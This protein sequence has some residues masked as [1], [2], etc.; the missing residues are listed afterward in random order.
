MIWVYRELTFFVRRQNTVLSSS[1]RSKD[2]N[3]IEKGA[4]ASCFECSG[5]EG[6]RKKGRIGFF[7]RGRLGI[8]LLDEFPIS[9][10]FNSFHIQ[11]D[12]NINNNAFSNYRINTFALR[13]HLQIYSL[14]RSPPFLPLYQLLFVPWKLSKLRIDIDIDIVP[15]SSI[16]YLLYVEG[17]YNRWRRRSRQTLFKPE[18]SSGFL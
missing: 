16:L 6:P 2:E 10:Q 11:T 3:R 8:Y 1:R 9:S 13:L 4:E 17:V 15:T 18:F 5:G 7:S 14:F 12:P